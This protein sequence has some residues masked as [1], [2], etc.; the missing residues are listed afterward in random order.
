MSMAEASKYR[1]FLS[2]SH[3]ESG[4]AK[5]VHARLEDFHIDRELIG[6]AEHVLLKFARGK[7]GSEN[8][9]RASKSPNRPHLGVSF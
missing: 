9:R 4:V 5:R 1:A 7:G 2:Y 3:A 8:D 6:R